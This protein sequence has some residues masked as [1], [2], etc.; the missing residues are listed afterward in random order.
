[1]NRT[2]ADDKGAPEA[3]ETGAGEPRE[4]LVDIPRG[5]DETVRTLQAR[6]LPDGSGNDSPDPD[7][8][9]DE[10]TERYDAG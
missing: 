1:M 9:P 2:P 6:P 8:R 3:D 4:E 10:D 7:E 5:N